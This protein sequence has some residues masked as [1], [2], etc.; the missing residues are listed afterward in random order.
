VWQDIG[1]HI[2]IVLVLHPELLDASD[3]SFRRLFSAFASPAAPVSGP[4]TSQNAPN[5]ADFALKFPSQP[6]QK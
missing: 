4:A 1:G 2:F 3:L 5:C 6:C